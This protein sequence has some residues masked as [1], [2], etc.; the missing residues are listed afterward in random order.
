MLAGSATVPQSRG[1]RFFET[2]ILNLRLSTVDAQ[3][4]CKGISEVVSA[5][6]NWGSK[7]GDREPPR[8][9]RVSLQR[10]SYKLEVRVSEVSERCGIRF[11]R[12]VHDVGFRISWE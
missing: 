8:S 5:R 9:T 10:T 4:E 3:L 11:A 7:K 1:D 2:E 6:K 12:K